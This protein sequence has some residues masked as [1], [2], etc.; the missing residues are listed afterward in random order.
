MNIVND[1]KW[2]VNIPE[3]KNPL[4]WCFCNLPPSSEQSAFRIARHPSNREICRWKSCKILIRASFKPGISR[5][6]LIRR[7]RWTGLISAPTFSSK[8]R[9]KARRE[10]SQMHKGRMN[11][12]RYPRGRVSEYLR[13]S[14]QRSA[15]HCSL[16]KSMA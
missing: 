10:A 16:A 11:Y 14:S 2:D 12:R 3:M 15:S 5:P 6:F 8:P 13:R 1:V 9:I 7:I 4:V